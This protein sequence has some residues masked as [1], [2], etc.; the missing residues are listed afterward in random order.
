VRDAVFNSLAARIPGSRV[1]DLFAG[2]GGFGLG[3]L[4]RGAARVVFVERDAALAE[5]IRR[6]VAKQ[7]WADRAQVLAGDVIAAVRALDRR[8]ESFDLL[9]MDPPYGGTWI[10]RMLRMLADTRLV[11]P[12]GLIIA[13]G[14]WRDRPADE[15]GFR[16][17]REARY[18][19]T[20]LWYY[21]GSGED[22]YDGGDLPGEL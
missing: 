2:S 5:G 12:G 20:A 3:M 10:P 17:L 8:E 13:E 4:A 11:A 6:Q 19:E 1:L 16:R 14:H 9:F 18:G 22:R 15:A 7:G 21:A